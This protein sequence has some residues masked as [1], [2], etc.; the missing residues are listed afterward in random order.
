[1]R[2]SVHSDLPF[3][4]FR[5]DP[6]DEWQMRE[7]AQR[8]GTRL[9]GKGKQVVSISLGE[10]M[11]EAIEASEGIDAIVELEKEHGFE[12][13]QDQVTTYLSDPNWRPLPDALA[14]KLSACDP[15]RHVAFL[16][17]AA[18]LAP[19]IYPISRLLDEMHGRTS[20]PAVLFYPGSIDGPTG[21]QFMGL[22]GRATL[23][24][25][26]VKIYG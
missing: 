14:E 18:A 19:S 5:Y 9:R 10:L 1:M 4:I 7:E 16:M 26:R 17:R 21:L 6:E 11:W 12:M 3:A 13:A 23:G 8:L 22:P 24:N 15:E 2:I 20:V 25:Y